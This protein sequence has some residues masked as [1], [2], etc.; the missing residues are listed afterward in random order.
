MSYRAL[1]QNLPLIKARVSDVGGLT[2]GSGVQA[3]SRNI[4]LL[5]DTGADMTCISVEILHDLMLP[6]LEKRAVSTPTGPGELGVYMAD[7]GIWLTDGSPMKTHPIRV[8]GFLGR[9][10]E[11]HGL[12]GRDLL[13]HYHFEMTQCAGYQL[14]PPPLS[15]R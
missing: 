10:P 3:L 7:V 13:A 15:R 5:V 4:T 6:R 9:A 2:P 14:L 11:Y 12:L 1:T 8:S